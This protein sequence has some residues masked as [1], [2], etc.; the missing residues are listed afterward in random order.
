MVTRNVILQHL[1]GINQVWI[2][3]FILV[4]CIDFVV[5]AAVSEGRFRDVV[6]AVSGLYR[7][8]FCLNAVIC[9]GRALRDGRRPSR[10]N[11]DL[12]D[13]DLS[14]LLELDFVVDAVRVSALLIGL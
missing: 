9:P 12:P 14:V 2:L 3:D 13:L 4:Q 7:V 1:S 8:S 5:P 11:F 10:I 6:E